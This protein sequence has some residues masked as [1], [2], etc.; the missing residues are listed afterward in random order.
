MFG[1]RRDSHGTQGTSPSGRWEGG[2][3]WKVGGLLGA[4][5]FGGFLGGL[6]EIPQSRTSPPHDARGPE[7]PL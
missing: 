7:A 4:P 2:L 6:L 3:W 1:A 5:P